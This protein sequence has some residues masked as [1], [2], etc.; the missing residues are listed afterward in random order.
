MQ[1]STKRSVTNKGYNDDEPISK[2]PAT[3]KQIKNHAE[4]DNVHY[5]DNSTSDDPGDLSSSPQGSNCCLVGLVTIACSISIVA[6][7]LGLHVLSGKIG[8]GCDC[9]INEGQFQ[10]KVTKP[11]REETNKK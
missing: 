7:L 4:E 8:N 11:D 10:T 6:L 5:C 2:K 1:A 9:S 3:L